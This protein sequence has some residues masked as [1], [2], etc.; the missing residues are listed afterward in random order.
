M[1]VDM[2]TTAAPSVA[3]AMLKANPLQGSSLWPSTRQTQL[4]SHDNGQ[5]NVCL[6]CLSCRQS[7]T[8][9][10][11]ALGGHGSAHEGNAAHLG[12]QRVDGAE[13]RTGARGTGCRGGCARRWRRRRRP[14]ARPPAPPRQRRSTSRRQRST[15]CII[16][17]WHL[18]ENV[19][20]RRKAELSS[21]REV[22]QFARVVRGA[23]A[24]CW[25][26]PWLSKRW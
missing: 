23:V 12:V 2:L 20:D 18:H 10:S 1:V 24:Q 7:T 13:A 26:C 17:G 8:A 19:D 11:L 5:L 25:E 14:S 3:K 4:Q 21:S 9:C 16:T 22:Q 6:R 15:S